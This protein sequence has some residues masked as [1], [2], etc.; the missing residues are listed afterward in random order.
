MEE[1]GEKRLE[2]LVEGRLVKA[3]V[4]MMAKSVD[5]KSM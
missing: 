4:E 1:M 5:G 3:M 2:I